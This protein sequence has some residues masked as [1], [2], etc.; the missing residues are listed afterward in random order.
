MAGGGGHL[1]RQRRRVPHGL[2]LP[3]DAPALHV[4]APGGPLPDHRH[5]G[6]DA[7]H[8][9]ERAVGGLPPQPRR[10]DA[11]DGHRRG[12]RLH[13]A[14]LLVGYGGPHQPRHP[15]PAG[16]ADAQQPAPGRAHERAP[17]LDARHP[18]RLLRRRDRDGRQHL[19]RR[20]QRRAHAD[21]VVGRPQ[22]RLLGGQPAAALPASDRRS[23]VP[24]RGR[25][26][27][28]AG[29]QRAV[30]AELDEAPDR[31]AQVAR[32]VRQR[33][34]RLPAPREPQGAG[35]RAHL[36]RGADPGR[37]QPRALPAVRAARPLAL[38]GP[39]AG[40]DVRPR[41][42]PSHHR[43]ALPGDAGSAQLLLVLAGSREKAGGRAQRPARGRA[44][45]GALGRP[46]G[47][48]DGQRPAAPGTDPTA[49]A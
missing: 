31:A 44:R 38:R 11:G 39:D 25:Q 37:R 16:S 30:A 10:A 41:R 27:R 7:P 45:A 42:V 21:A 22:R 19:P 47:P 13:V 26:R 35:V 36:R 2:P 23:R 3:A 29:G 1:F 15:P 49:S 20:P 46:R 8:P 9:R 48:A 12:A 24:L 5:H 6:A 18:G 17:L 4:G 28:G 34:A 14:R 43:H 40:G 32:R 33:D